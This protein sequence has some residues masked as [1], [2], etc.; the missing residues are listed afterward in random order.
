MTLTVFPIVSGI[1]TDP[2]TNQLFNK[3]YIVAPTGAIGEF[4]GKENH[5]AFYSAKDGWTLRLAEVG[6]RVFIQPTQ[7][8]YEWDGESWRDYFIVREDLQRVFAE[9]TDFDSLKAAIAAL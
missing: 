4:E 2:S 9:A 6:K 7:D 1:I 3:V 5:M 8:W